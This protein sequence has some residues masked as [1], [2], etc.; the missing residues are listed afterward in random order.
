MTEKQIELWE[1]KAKSGLLRGDTILSGATNQ[2]RTDFY[3]NVSVNGESLQLTQFGITTSS[4]YSQRGHLEINEEKLKAKIKEDPDS[5]AN[6]F[7]AGTSSTEN[8]NEKGIMR[9][10]Q[11]VLT[12]TKKQIEDKA[13]NS[14]MANNQFTIGKNLNTVES[15]ISSMNNR[16]TQIENRYYTKFTAM[17][18]AIQKMNEQSTYLAQLLGQ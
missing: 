15:D 7:M 14:A 13:G 3:S 5:V 16:L 2:M 1:E 4:V 18:K 6:L 8:Y 12:D 10:L 17:E 11:T 9:R